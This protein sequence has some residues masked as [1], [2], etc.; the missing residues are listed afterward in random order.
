MKYQSTANISVEEK[1]F[2]VLNPRLAKVSNSQKTNQLST[3]L[4][5]SSSI[6]TPAHQHSKEENLC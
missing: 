2:Y 1:I 5:G 6:S 3:E 4:E